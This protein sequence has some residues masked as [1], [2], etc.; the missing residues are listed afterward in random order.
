MDILGNIKSGTRGVVASV[1]GSAGRAWSGAGDILHGVGERAGNMASGARNAG[2]S[3]LRGTGSALRGTGEFA[4][5][6]SSDIRNDSDMLVRGTGKAAKWSAIGLGIAAAVGTVMIGVAAVFDSGR[7]QR[8]ARR[9]GELTEAAALAQNIA[10]K[11]A[12]IADMKLQRAAAVEAVAN[13]AART[14]NTQKVVTAAGQAQVAP[15]PSV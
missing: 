3:V 15:T 10:E 5:Q 2:S 6:L 11:Q 1:Q 9:G 12:L 8:E 7:K 13:P 4:A 14:D